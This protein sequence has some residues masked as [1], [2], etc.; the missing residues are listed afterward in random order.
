M[1]SHTLRNKKTT[2]IVV[3]DEAMAAVY[4]RKSR[5]ASLTGLF[6]LSNEAGRKKTGELISDR[7]G[8]A[9]DS[10]GQGRHTMAKEKT[11]PKRQASAVFA[12]SI[13]QRINS[14]I[15]DKSCDEFVLV[16]APRFLG[17]LRDALGKT[18]NAVPAL[19][20]DKEMTGRDAADIQQ[21][22]ANL[23]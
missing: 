12:K 16:A 14:A 23:E 5:H 1:I 18:G 15:L 10:H 2:W 6:E 4:E 17:Q 22:L 8:R 3:A 9:F 19:T 7:G 21:L 13:A 20:I 11:S